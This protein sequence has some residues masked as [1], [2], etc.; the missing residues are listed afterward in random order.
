MNRVT[1]ADQRLGCDLL[2]GLDIDDGLVMNFEL[3]RFERVT[4]I[5]FKFA[6][7]WRP[8]IHCRS[9]FQR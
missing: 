2:A 6:P 3:A 5:Q 8:R 4:Q 1:P 7:F 9:P